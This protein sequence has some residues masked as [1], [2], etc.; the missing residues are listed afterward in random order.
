MRTQD[1]ERKRPEHQYPNRSNDITSLKTSFLT[2]MDDTEEEKKTSLVLKLN[3]GRVLKPGVDLSIN[4][5]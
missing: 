3:V 1:G 5:K 4:S 2:E